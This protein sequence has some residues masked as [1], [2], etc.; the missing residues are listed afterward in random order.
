MVA[1][2]VLIWAEWAAEREGKAVLVFTAAFTHYL[3]QKALS[4]P[5]ALAI[6]IP[7]FYQETVEILRDG[8]AI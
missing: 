6:H 8:K 5:P 3:F 2:K 1:E 4:F 7:Q